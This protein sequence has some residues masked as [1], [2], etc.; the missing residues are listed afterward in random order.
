MMAQSETGYFYDVMVEGRKKEN[1]LK[2]FSKNYLDE[3]DVITVNGEYFVITE[4]DG[5]DIIAKCVSDNAEKV[6][7]VI[8]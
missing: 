2:I 6:M 7:L 3:K 1:E 8:E 4:V 5:N